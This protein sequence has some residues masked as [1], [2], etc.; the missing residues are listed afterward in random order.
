MDPRT[1]EDSFSVARFRAQ[2]HVN[3]YTLTIIGFITLS[4]AA[5]GYAASNIATTLTQPSFQE[6]MGL[7]TNPDSSAIVGAMNALFQ[8]GAV[9]GTFLAAWTSDRYG[10]KVAAGIGNLLILV[11]GACLTGSVNPAMFI[12]FRFVSGL[13]YVVVSP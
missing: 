1:T 4:S 10:R 9:F 6:Y 13:G 3:F 7:L 2:Q 11:S 5:Y 12:V 8:A